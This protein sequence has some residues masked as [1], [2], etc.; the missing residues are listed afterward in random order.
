M[1]FRRVLRF[2]L[3]NVKE[4]DGVWLGNAKDILRV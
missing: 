1:V 3:G 4:S 2:W